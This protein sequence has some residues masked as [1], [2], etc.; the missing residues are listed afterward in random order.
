[1]SS[2]A[3]CTYFDSAYAPRGRVLIDTLRRQGDDSPVHVLALDDAAFVEVSSW[4]DLG[5]RV[6]TLS[7]LVETFPQ[8]IAARADRSRMEYVFT[9]TP[10]LTSWSM[11]EVA[12]GSWVTY[13]DADMAFFSSTSPIYE[14]LADASIG[15]VEHRFTW[16]QAWRR[17][18]GRYNVAWVGFRND[19]AGRICLQW[20]ADQCLDWCRDEVDNGRFADQGYLDRF[21]ELF[22]GVTTIELPG[23]DVAPWNLRRHHVSSSHNGDVLIDGKPLIFFHFHGL[24]IEG[25]R[26]YFKHVPYLAKTTSAIRDFVYRPYCEALLAASGPTSRSSRVMERRPRLLDSLKSGRVATIRWLGVRRGDYV[27]IQV[28]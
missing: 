9:L 22:S 27:D 12:E 23:A 15:I 5:V 13:L 17:K 20:W 8:L 4:S 2:H 24:R 25:T 21:P 28:P 14:E 18:Y 26:F 19:E 7:E 3:Y 10:W 1:M 11:R 16:E 6:L